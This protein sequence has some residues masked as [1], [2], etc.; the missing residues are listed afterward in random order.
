MISYNI[1]YTKCII[2]INTKT[3]GYKIN[4]VNINE[5][6]NLLFFL[7]VFQN[8]ILRSVYKTSFYAKIK[9]LFTLC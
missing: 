1:I 7:F 6:L 2:Q 5:I 3:S 8:E 9:L 4:V